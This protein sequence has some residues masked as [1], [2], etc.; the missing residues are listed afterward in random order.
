MRGILNLEIGERIKMFKGYSL[1]K[2]RPVWEF[3]KFEQALERHKDEYLHDVSPAYIEWKSYTHELIHQRPRKRIELVDRWTR[4]HTTYMED[5]IQFDERDVW[6]S[7]GQLVKSRLG[8]CED[9]AFMNM[10]GLRMLNFNSWILRVRMP[11]IRVAKGKTNYHMICCVE[12]GDDILLLDDRQKEVVPSTMM[13]G[14]YQPNIGYD[15][16][17]WW[18]YRKEHNV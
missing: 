13:R 8:D 5:Q 6:L 1:S 14:Y 18:R 16:H 2:R 17:G 4:E 7:P 9:D 3:P 11:R 15:P 10:C 12:Y